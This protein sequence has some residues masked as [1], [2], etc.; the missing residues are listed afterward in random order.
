[1][2]NITKMC[3][4][5]CWSSP[6][7]VVLCAGECMYADTD[8]AC[9]TCTIGLLLLVLAFFVTASVTFLDEQLVLTTQPSLW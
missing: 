7:D 4:E 9:Y 1:M 6:S 2:G 5:E 8:T 3:I